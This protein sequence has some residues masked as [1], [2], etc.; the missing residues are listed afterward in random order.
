MYPPAFCPSSARLGQESPPNLAVR[1]LGNP[2][3]GQEV[4]VE[5]RGAEGQP[6][7]YV[8]SNLQGQLVSERLVEQAGALE[9]QRLSV[10]RQP[11]GVLLLR[12][13][14]PSQHQTVKILTAQ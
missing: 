4:A 11:A 13:S 5:V 7:R 1:V 2:V 6:L 14:T 3:T 9:R 10:G 8:L 12:V